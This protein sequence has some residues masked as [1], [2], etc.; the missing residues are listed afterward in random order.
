MKYIIAMWLTLGFS[1]AFMDLHYKQI[2]YT[3]EWGNASV[4]KALVVNIIGGPAG[5]AACI[6]NY[7]NRRT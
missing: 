5:M 2:G 6:G 7:L 3:G 4:A 1:S